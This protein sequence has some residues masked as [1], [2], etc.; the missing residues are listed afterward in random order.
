MESFLNENKFAPAMPPGTFLDSAGGHSSGATDVWV[1]GSYHGSQPF[2]LRY[3]TDK[4]PAT[5]ISMHGF[6]LWN[7]RG[8]D[9]DRQKIEAATNEFSKKLQDMA[10]AYQ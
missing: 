8:N 2:Y 9:A 5:S 7:I 1:M 3:Y 6:T 4:T 10:A